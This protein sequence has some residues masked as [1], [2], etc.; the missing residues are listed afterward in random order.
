L[1][2][3]AVKAE[4]SNAGRNGLIMQLTKEE[5]VILN[6]LLAPNFSEDPSNERRF[7]KTEIDRKTKDLLHSHWS[8]AQVNPYHSAIAL[9]KHHPSFKQGKLASVSAKGELHSLAIL[10]GSC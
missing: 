6:T 7:T 2:Q 9:A 1:R 5:R 10:D 8:S 4:D 3:Q